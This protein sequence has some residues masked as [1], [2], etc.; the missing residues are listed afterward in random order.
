MAFVNA[1]ML[2]SLPARRAAEEDRD[3]NLGEKGEDANDSEQI[4]QLMKKDR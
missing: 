2:I 3:R 4:V 1:R